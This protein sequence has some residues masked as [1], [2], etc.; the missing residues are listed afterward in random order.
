MVKQASGCMRK[1]LERGHILKSACC[2][3]VESTDPPWS[4]VSSPGCALQLTLTSDSSIGSGLGGKHVESTQC[5]L[6]D[7][8]TMPHPQR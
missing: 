3:Y 1:S 2:D 4:P 8:G 7:T 5:G 6:C